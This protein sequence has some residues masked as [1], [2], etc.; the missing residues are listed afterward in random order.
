MTLV[1]INLKVC[2]SYSKLLIIISALVE[3]CL[4]AIL[5]P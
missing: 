5:G 2:K 3:L 1:R 4:M